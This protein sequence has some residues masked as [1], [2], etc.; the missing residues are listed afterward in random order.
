MSEDTISRQAAIDAIDEIES[1]VADGDGF[2]YDKWRRHFCDLPSAE[3]ESCEYWDAESNYCALNRP[4]A[5][6]EPEEFEWC[7]GCKEYD[8]EAHCCHRWTKAIRNTVEEIKNAQPE[9]RWIPVKTRPMDEEEKRYWEEHYAYTFGEDY[10]GIMFDCPMPEDGQ[11]VWVCS[12][13]GYVWEDTC[14]VDIGFGL[15]GNGD[16]DDIV[17]WMPFERPEPW[18]GENDET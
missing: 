18:K 7:T 4:S 8:Q 16:W 3:P 12:K 13:S 11:E 2:Q 1:E 17:A 14:E 9:P 15:E 6:P 5:Q 10:D